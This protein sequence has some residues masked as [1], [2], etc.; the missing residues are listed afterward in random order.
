MQIVK[1]SE[2]YID[3]SLKQELTCSKCSTIY[4]P[5]RKDLHRGE[6]YVKNKLCRF[7]SSTLVDFFYAECPRCGEVSSK[8][9]YTHP[10]VQQEEV[11]NEPNETKEQPKEEKID[12]N[13]YFDHFIAFMIGAFTMAMILSMAF[14][15]HGCSQIADDLSHISDSLTKNS[16]EH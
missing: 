13:K 1:E 15:Y 4:I 6:E 3:F 11:K 16:N 12:L 5:E 10:P 7:G 9:Y 2:K 14:I 8:G